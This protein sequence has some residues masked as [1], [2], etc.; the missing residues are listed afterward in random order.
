MIPWLQK[1]TPLLD[2]KY[3]FYKLYTLNRYKHEILQLE[4]LLAGFQGTIGAVLAISKSL[5]LKVLTLHS[6]EIVVFTLG[7]QVTL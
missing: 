5:N 6:H 7:R 2:M 1:I 4:T 3:D